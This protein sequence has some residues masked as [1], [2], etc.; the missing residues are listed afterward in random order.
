MPVRV[1]HDSHCLATSA[2]AVW[3]LP[4]AA[5]V[6]GLLEFTIH[7]NLI[8]RITMISMRTIG[9]SLVLTAAAVG[10]NRDR[11][12]DRDHAPVPGGARVIEGAD[13]PTNA[14]TPGAAGTPASG[15]A[16][17]AVLPSQLPETPPIDPAAGTT[18]GNPG[19]GTVGT[20]DSKVIEDGRG[21]PATT[22]SAPSAAGVGTGDQAPTAMASDAG[23]PSDAGTGSGSGASKGSGAGSGSAAK[24]PR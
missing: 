16:P 9:L 23:V 24:R 20:S 21:Q 15:A 17:G 18:P 12:S 8:R 2:S 11:A 22:D 10:C 1:A 7:K 19:T 13:T 5:N 3:S 6:G 14:A 4:D